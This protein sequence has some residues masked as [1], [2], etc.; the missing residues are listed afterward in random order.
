MAINNNTPG[1]PK[2]PVV[3]KVNTLKGKENPVIVEKLLNK[4]IQ[5]TPHNKLMPIRTKERKARSP[6]RKAITSNNKPQQPTAK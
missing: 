2:I 3:N 6:L 4:M 5:P 1:I